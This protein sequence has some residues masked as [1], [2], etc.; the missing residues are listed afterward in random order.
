[1]NKIVG[2]DEEDRKFI[3]ENKELV[4]N[5]LSKKQNVETI[6]DEVKDKV[7]EK[8]L[9]NTE[10]GKEYGNLRKNKSKVVN[11]E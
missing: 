6:F 9:E 1:V 2:I 4:N 8:R 5:Q 11:T 3:R 10:M 7:S